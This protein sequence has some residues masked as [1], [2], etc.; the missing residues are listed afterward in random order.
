MSSD[1]KYQS[2]VD[3][4]QGCDDLARVVVFLRPV[5][6]KMQHTRSRLTLGLVLGPVGV[7]YKDNQPCSLLFF[8]FFFFVG[9]G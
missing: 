5:S 8:V 4:V 7:C 3:D 6:P 2:N 1:I 9:C